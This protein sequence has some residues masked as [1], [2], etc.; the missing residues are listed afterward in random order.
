M[1]IK[2][3]KNKE[4][5]D[6]LFQS[7]GK[8]PLVKL[9]KIPKAEGIDA[10]ILV[11]LEYVNPTGSLKDRIYLKMITKAIEAGDLKPGM[12]I[13]EASTGNAG[14]ACTFIGGILGYTAT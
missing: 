13:I 1:A 4:T 8:T 5:L 6:D 11:K 12:E 2:W 10:D 9:R 3:N 14:I 7:I